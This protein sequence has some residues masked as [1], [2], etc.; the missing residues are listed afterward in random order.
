MKANSNFILGVNILLAVLIFISSYFALRGH[1][2]SE[3]SRH[4]GKQSRGNLALQRQKQANKNNASVPFQALDSGQNRP[5]LLALGMKAHAMPKLPTHMM[6]HDLF[7]HYKQPEDTKNEDTM[8]HTKN[9]VQSQQDTIVTLKNTNSAVQI[10]QVS[11]TSSSKAVA[12]AAKCT[13][14]FEE[15]CEMY[16]Y[17]RYWNTHFEKRDCFESPARHPLKAKAPPSEQKYLVFEPD[18]GAWNNIR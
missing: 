10:P 4:D 17:V 5:D 14:H 13:H 1:A 15:Q 7:Q 8:K 6:N 12:G 16:P 3:A 11:D 18:R 2:D 9:G